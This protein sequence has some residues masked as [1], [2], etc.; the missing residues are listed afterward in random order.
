MLISKT[1]FFVTG[2]AV[3]LTLK[4][5]S[6]LISSA[7]FNSAN[8]KSSDIFLTDKLNKVLAFSGQTFILPFP[9]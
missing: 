1:N 2:L 3:R 4:N 9:H 6:V 5:V 8:F 7:E